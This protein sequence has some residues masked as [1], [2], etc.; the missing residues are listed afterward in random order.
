MQSNEFKEYR[1]ATINYMHKIYEEG[2][3]KFHS[4]EN[5][6][7]LIRQY[8]PERVDYSLNSDEIFFKY[9]KLDDRKFKSKDFVGA[10]LDCN[11]E[12][13][14]EKII[15]EIFSI[16]TLLNDNFFYVK[17]RD[18][19]SDKGKS[20]IYPIM[21][22][23]KNN[24]DES[25]PL[26][27]DFNNESYIDDY[28]FY[29]V[30]YPST[31]GNHRITGICESI[32]LIK[33][34]S[35]KLKHRVRKI[36]KKEI[37]ENAKKFIEIIANDELIERIDILKVDYKKFTIKVEQVNQEIIEI[38]CDS[39]NEVFDL[40]LTSKYQTIIKYINDL[41][42]NGIFISK[43]NIF[44]RINKVEIEQRIYS[45][46]LVE[47][48]RQLNYAYKTFIKCC[49]K[50]DY[51]KRASFINKRLYIKNKNITTVGRKLANKIISIKQKEQYKIKRE[52]RKKNILII[53]LVIITIIGSIIY[54]SYPLYE[55]LIK[56]YAY[57]FCEDYINRNQFDN[58]IL[59]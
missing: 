26:N 55:D 22:F 44:C 47:V 6:I 56:D 19:A 52:K 37:M 34:C 28:H 11:L 29:K 4:L 2:G 8:S 27:L 13:T 14:N 39:I 58:V 45:D 18:L 23:R 32:G 35:I 50:L 53:S 51:K 25:K 41:E 3:K 12:K 15:G 57:S 5:A 21:T 40:V 48:A 17:T 54:Y 42:H 46:D 16:N 1:K 7:N 49:I 43:D 20:C 9:F 30:I 31:S 36:Y 24:F 59:K 33:D 38:G 10:Y